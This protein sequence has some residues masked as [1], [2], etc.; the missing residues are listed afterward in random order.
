MD[1]MEGRSDIEFFEPTPLS[2]W[3]LAANFSS[4]F[5]FFTIIRRK[6]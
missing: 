3:S 1:K 4:F 6:T 2:D 5:L